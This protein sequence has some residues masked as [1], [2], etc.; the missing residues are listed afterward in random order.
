MIS[1]QR[2]I[3]NIFLACYFF[4]SFAYGA[5][6][7]PPKVGNF[8]LP[9]TQQPGSLIGLGQNIINKK[10]TQ[11]S[12]IAADFGGVGKYFTSVIPILRYGMT[13]DLTFGVSVPVTPIQK[14]NKNRSAGLEDAFLQLEYAFYG[15]STYCFVDQATILATVFAPTG[16]AKKVPATGNGATSYLLGGSFE[17]V[18]TDWFFFTSYAAIV[19]QSQNDT[20]FGNM[21]LYQG[22]LGRNIFNIDSKWIFA[23]MAEVDGDYSKR[24]KINGTTDPNSGGNVVY[25][26]P[27]LWLSSKDWIFQLGV[28]YAVTQ[29]LYGDQKRNTYLVAAQVQLIL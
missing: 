8:M 1:I 29:N 7:E 23:G 16:S 25:V 26:M 12:L 14:E 13:D 24:N 3:K 20:R 18:Y 22:G 19:A 17:R 15:K 27:S 28:G 11:W 21:Y 6:Q 4:S 2:V 10:Q 9:N 5:D